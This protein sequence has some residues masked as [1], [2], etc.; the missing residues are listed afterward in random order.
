MDVDRRLFSI[1]KIKVASL[2]FLGRKFWKKGFPVVIFG[3]VKSQ[4]TGFLY[5]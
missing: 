4:N 1:E 5:V 2:D 3:K